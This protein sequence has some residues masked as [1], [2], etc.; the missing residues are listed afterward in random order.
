[1]IDVYIPSI[2]EKK[3]LTINCVTVKWLNLMIRGKSCMQNVW[4]KKLTLQTEYAYR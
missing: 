4:Y 1:V 3:N 2:K